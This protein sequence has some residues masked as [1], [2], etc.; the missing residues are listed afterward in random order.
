MININYHAHRI[1]GIC[2]GLSFSIATMPSENGLTYLA[3][4]T[5]SSLVGS[6]LPDIDEPQSYIGKKVKPISK[7]IKFTAGHRGLFHTL[8]MCFAFPFIYFLINDI[9][10]IQNFINI[11]SYI[12]I[13]LPIGYLS[14]L[15]MDMM[16]V[17]GVP[18]FWPIINKKISILPLKTN[19]DEWIAI[20]LFIIPVVLA[21]NFHFNIF[22]FKFN[23]C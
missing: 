18:L 7:A 20:L 19:R 12:I 22:Q 6:L 1:S 15:L 17:S 11:I 16:T 4:I 14:H 10:Q 21:L 13:G 8:L 3:V 2:V 5:G 9:P 23:S